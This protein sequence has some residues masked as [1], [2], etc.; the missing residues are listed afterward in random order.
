MSI[1][2]DGATPSGVSAN[3]PMTFAELVI[4]ANRNPP[5]KQ[6]FAVSAPT[7]VSP[8][9][10]ELA[11]ANMPPDKVRLSRRIE[12]SEEDVDAVLSE[13][14]QARS[15]RGDRKAMRRPIRRD[16][17]RD[18]FDAVRVHLRRLCRRVLNDRALASQMPPSEALL[19]AALEAYLREQCWHLVY[20]QEP[21]EPRESSK[22]RRSYLDEA[23]A[24]EAVARSSAAYALTQWRPDYIIEQQRRGRVGGRISKRL[25]TWT[26]ADLDQLAQLDGLT[27]AEQAARLDR[28]TRTL[29]RMRADLRGRERSA[30]TEPAG[31]I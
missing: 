14:I 8:N 16:N 2:P 29:E 31:T 17:Q 13:L 6:L 20:F 24:I 23:R 21:G 18:L 12:V 10:I 1:V 25:P 7:A 19:Q 22:V 5:D 9:G 4:R 30:S 27:V 28:S 3:R 11:S 26:V 15:A